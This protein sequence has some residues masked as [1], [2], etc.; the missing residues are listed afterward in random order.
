MVFHAKEHLSARVRSESRRLDSKDLKVH[1]E[2]H[3]L[4][5]EFQELKAEVQE[6]KADLRQVK[7]ELQ[8]IKADVQGLH[9]RSDGMSAEL[10][11]VVL[12]VGRWR[13]PIGE[14]VLRSRAGGIVVYNERTKDAVL[15]PG[16]LPVLLASVR[17]NR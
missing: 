7:A 2:V 8:E 9:S 10:D 16:F 1:G 4:R 5:S 17:Q 14:C 13:R 3:G 6:V 12:L 15:H 11:R